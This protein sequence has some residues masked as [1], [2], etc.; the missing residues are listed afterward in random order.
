MILA[1]V[2]KL[3]QH[4]THGVNAG[5]LLVIGLDGDP[6]L[7]RPPGLQLGEYPGE[8]PASDAADGEKPA[9]AGVIPRETPTPLPPE[10]HGKAYAGVETPYGVI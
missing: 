8:N 1:G 6:G 7:P 5:A 9:A 2:L 3:A 10:A 4:V